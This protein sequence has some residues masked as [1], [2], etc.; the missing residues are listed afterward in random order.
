VDKL[1]I[2]IIR[3]MSQAQLMVPA[4]VGLRSSY[5]DMAKKLE[6]SPGTIRNRVLKM[7]SSGILGGSS[8][9]VNPN[10]IGLKGGTYAVDVSPKLSKPEVLEKLKSLRNTLFIHDFRGGLVGFAFVY[11][12]EK[13]MDETVAEF[14]RICGA[15]KDRGIVSEVDYPPCSIAASDAE[16]RLISRLSGGSFDSYSQ[17]AR[18]LKVSVRTLKRRL[19][20]LNSERA[21]LSVPTLNY[22][23]IRGGLPADVIVV[24]LSPAS[25]AEAEKKILQLVGDYMVFAGIAREYIVYNLVLPN[26]STLSDIISSIGKI[27]GLTLRAEIVEEHIDVT[28]H[29]GVYMVE[30]R[31][32]WK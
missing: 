5:R 17:L 3:E 27:E 1:D 18:E 22:R 7:Y 13:G 32:A 30:R 21:I 28:K 24:F 12:P 15:E 4:R 20:K 16:W 26:I 25:R 10:L 8:I 2:V 31:Q 6:S 23:A 19:T 29:L 11:E 14:N 9:Y